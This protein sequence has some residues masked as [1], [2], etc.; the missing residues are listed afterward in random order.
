MIVSDTGLCWNPLFIHLERQVAK[1]NQPILFIAPF[2]KLD[3][4]RK[5]LNYI[6]DAGLLKIVGRWTGQ[7]IVA[8]AS[9]IA[10]YPFLR[11]RG[12]PLYINNK[13]CFG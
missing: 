10:I 11:E 4:L 3:A 8:G 5:T 9:D 6:T 12:I 13:I 7:D 2:I 1:N